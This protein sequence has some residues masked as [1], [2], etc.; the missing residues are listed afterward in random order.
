MNTI[1]D[2]E[3]EHKRKRAI[4]N[5]MYFAFLFGITFI[6]CLPLEQ[7]AKTAIVFI[8][9]IFMLLIGKDELL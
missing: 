8:L 4:I 3:R 1:I 2:I 9:L 7:R 6:F 5:L